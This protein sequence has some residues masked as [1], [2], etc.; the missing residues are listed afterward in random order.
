M[1]K[2]GEPG[3]RLSQ[4]EISAAWLAWIKKGAHFSM[5]FFVDVDLLF[6]KPVKKGKRIKAQ[7]SFLLGERD[8]LNFM[9]VNR[10]SGS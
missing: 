7:S 4:K 2:R 3:T 1:A 10:G 6:G 8:H 5:P 9:K